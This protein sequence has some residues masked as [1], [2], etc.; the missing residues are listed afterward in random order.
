MKAHLTETLKII[1]G[2][3]IMAVV[4]QYFS[5]NGEFTVKTDSRNL[6]N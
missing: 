4:F 2:I 1:T 6:V 3:L 5:S